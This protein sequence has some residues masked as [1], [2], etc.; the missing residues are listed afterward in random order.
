M[1]AQVFGTRKSA[2]TRKA[3]RFFS[4]RG[5]KTHFVDLSQRPLSRGELRHFVERFGVDYLIDHAGNRFRELGLAAAS[6]EPSRWFERLLAEPLLLRQPLVRAQNRFSV[7][8]A[9]TDWR[10]WVRG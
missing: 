1:E 6:P 10:Q 7:G 5:W 9:E 8:D 2:G 3:L 4:E